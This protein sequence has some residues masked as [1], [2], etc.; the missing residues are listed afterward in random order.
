ML[1]KGKEGEKEHSTALK[2]LQN[3]SKLKEALHMA[4]QK[5]V[6]CT[7]TSN[8]YVPNYASQFV[9]LNQ[10]VNLGVTYS[11]QYPFN[12]QSILSSGTDSLC[13]AYLIQVFIY[14][15]I[16]WCFYIVIGYLYNTCTS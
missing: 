11:V 14:S 1:I 7:H 13:P 6:T 5:Y 12:F 8:L 4:K 3:G 16:G 15:V 9:H 2:T 10:C